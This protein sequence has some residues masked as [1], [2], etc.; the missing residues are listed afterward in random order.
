MKKILSILLLLAF[1]VAAWAQEQEMTVVERNAAQG[2][3]DTI[4]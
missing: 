4:D 2:F 1:F 3:N